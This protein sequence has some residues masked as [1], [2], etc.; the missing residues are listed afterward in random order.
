MFSLQNGGDQFLGLKPPAEVP[1]CCSPVTLPLLKV[2]L[3][4]LATSVPPGDWSRNGCVSQPRESWNCHWEIHCPLEELRPLW[5]NPELPGTLE[6]APPEAL[7]YPPL[8]G[9]GTN[10]SFF[11]WEGFLRLLSL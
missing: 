2:F 6:T 8:F 11:C 10:R 9:T 4:V 7:S 1:H 3:F 5:M